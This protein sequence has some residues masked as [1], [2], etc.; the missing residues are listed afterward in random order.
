MTQKPDTLYGKYNLLPSGNGLGLSTFFLVTHFLCISTLRVI[1]CKHLC[2]LFAVLI[3]KKSFHNEITFSMHQKKS[4]IENEEYYCNR[5]MVRTKKAYN[6]VNRGWEEAFGI[7]F[8]GSD[9]EGF[10]FLILK[11]LLAGSTALKKTPKTWTIVPSNINP[12]A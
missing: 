11:T 1:Y 2:V 5:K 8:L 10:S 3:H 4:Q 12:I 7:E 9:S 6:F